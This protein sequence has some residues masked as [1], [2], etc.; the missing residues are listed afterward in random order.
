ME[1]LKQET[2][3][4]FLS[5]PK[6][7]QMFKLVGTD[8]HIDIQFDGNSEQSKKEAK[9]VFNFLLNNGLNR[10]SQNHKLKYNKKT[11]CLKVYDAFNDNI[12]IS[13]SMPDTNNKNF[14]KLK[15]HLSEII[16]SI[17]VESK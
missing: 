8:K 13:M 3:I 17:N 4:N 1:N 14:G 11:E 2:H 5:K 7:N 6:V 15:K 9:Q 10:Y 12:I 16:Q